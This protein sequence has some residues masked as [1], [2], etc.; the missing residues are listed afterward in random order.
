[1]RHVINGWWSV[2][3][4]GEVCHVDSLLWLPFED[5][6]C[7]Q[8][9]HQPDPSKIDGGYRLE[10]DG[11]GAVHRRQSLD[12]EGKM[13]PSDLKNEEEGEN[14]AAAVRC[15]YPSWLETEVVVRSDLLA[16]RIEEGEGDACHGHRLQSPALKTMEKGDELVAVA[17]RSGRRWGDGLRSRRIRTPCLIAVILDG[18]D[19]S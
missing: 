4:E 2:S 18:S 15:C 11:N 19:Q 10:V 13:Q 7:H 17:V 6:C 16:R 12:L 8:L 1:M 14:A 9:N 3:K 5:W